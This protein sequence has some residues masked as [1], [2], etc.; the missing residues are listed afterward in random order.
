MKPL[1][2]VICLTYNHE[3]YISTTLDSILSQKTNFNFEIIIHNDASTDNTKNI[4]EL[5]NKKKYNNISFKI[6]NQTTNMYSIKKGYITNFVFSKVNGKYIAMCEGDDYWIDKNKL[7]K[8]VNLLEKYNN[9]SMCFNKSIIVD[10]NNNFVKYH[11]KIKKDKIY[12]I[13]DLFKNNFIS[14]ASVMYRYNII[15][16]IPSNFNNIYAFDWLLNLISASNG[17][18]FY[19]NDVMSAYRRHSKGIWT[20]LK[21]KER[22]VFKIKTLSYFNELSNYKYNNFIINE[23]NKLSS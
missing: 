14:T 17:S 12:T 20:K 5:Y 13:Y 19:F 23:I 21:Q 9:F 8:Q 3:K 1:V 22:N 4:I 10:K 11:N 2:S 7:Q 18:F 16:N 6:Y 15:K